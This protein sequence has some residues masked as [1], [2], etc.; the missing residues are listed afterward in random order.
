M[1][2]G[3]PAN[4]TRRQGDRTNLVAR[5][6][7]SIDAVKPDALAAVVGVAMR[8][9]APQQFMPPLLRT[10]GYEFARL[11]KHAEP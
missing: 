3:R 5:A 8:A 11:S 9:M 2:P 1:P 10:S 7:D 4:T 6:W